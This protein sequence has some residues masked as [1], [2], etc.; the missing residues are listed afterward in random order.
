VD[1]GRIRFQDNTTGG[2]LEGE[3][4]EAAAV[5]HVNLALNKMASAGLLE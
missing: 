3:R 1:E 5:E 2:E 4:L